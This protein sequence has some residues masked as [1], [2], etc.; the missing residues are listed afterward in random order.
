MEKIK[1]LWNKLVARIYG[2][3]GIVYFPDKLATKTIGNIEVI[4]DLRVEMVARGLMSTHIT[5]NADVI[6]KIAKLKGQER[7]DAISKTIDLVLE[8]RT[9][10][11]SE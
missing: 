9:N 3:F 10:L 6:N 4:K 1:L 7:K 2:S 8:I 11:V 5:W